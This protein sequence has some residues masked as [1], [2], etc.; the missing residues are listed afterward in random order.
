MEYEQRF[1]NVKNSNESKITFNNG[2][3]TRDVNPLEF[4]QTDS[5]ESCTQLVAS[6]TI[7]RYASRKFVATE[8]VSA[9]FARIRDDSWLDGK[10]KE[11][12]ELSVGFNAIR[13]RNKRRINQP[14]P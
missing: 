11:P 3:S 7:S 4:H 10:E 2:G 8:C 6:V 1:A 14:L 13:S 9:D 12:W 5:R